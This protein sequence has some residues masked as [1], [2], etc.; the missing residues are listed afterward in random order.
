[1]QTNNYQDGSNISDQV[2]FELIT[3]ASI[4]QSKMKRR[5]EK[6]KKYKETENETSTRSGQPRVIIVLEFISLDFSK[7]KWEKV[8]LDLL[9]K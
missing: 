4:Q 5:K 7:I 9:D 2:S 1:M 3:C 8:I 6:R